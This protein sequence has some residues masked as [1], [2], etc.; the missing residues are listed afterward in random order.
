MLMS[1]P[2]ITLS[3]GNYPPEPNFQTVVK[4]PEEAAVEADRLAQAGV[5]VIKA[6]PMSR[7][8]YEKVVESAHRNKLKVHAHVY[9]EQYV[10]DAFE[11]GVDVLTHVGS[12]G[13]TP[14]Y[15]PEMI[16]DIVNAGRPVVV[17]AAHR[18]WVYPDDDSVS[19]AAPGSAVEE[20]LP[21]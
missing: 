14:P 7:A 8:H 6:Y 5:D 15:S 21:A 13:D 11:A 1:G 16:R 2:W 4:T 20:G 9:G 12:A 18:A 10:R 3:P 19:R 17:T